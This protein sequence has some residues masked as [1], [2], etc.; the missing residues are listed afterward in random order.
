LRGQ[1]WNTNFIMLAM[2]NFPRINI[3]V[4]LWG[5]ML[6]N[7]KSQIDGIWTILPVL[8]TF[9][10]CVL[11][12]T[13]G[14]P[15]VVFAIPSF[16][17]L[18]AY[19][20][21]NEAPNGTPRDEK[22]P[23]YVELWDK[24]DSSQI[25]ASLPSPS[26]SVR[27][28]GSFSWMP[29]GSPLL[30]DIDLIVPAGSSLA[31]LGKVGSGKT[32][33]IMATLGELFPQG[34]ARI[35]IPRTIAF[36][37]QM[38][39]IMEGTLRGNVLSCGALDAERYNQ[40]I[41]ASCLSPDLEIL[42]GGDLV[43]IGSRGIALSGGQRARVSIARVA[44]SH[45]TVKVLDD[46]FSAL[47]ARTSRHVLDHY[48]FGDLLKNTT[49]IVVSQPDKDRIQRYDKVIILSEGRIACQGTPEEI[50][51]TEAYR[52][53]LNTE[54]AESLDQGKGATKAVEKLEVKQM[55][56]IRNSEEGFKLRDEE[57]QGRASWNDIWWF[58][59]CGGVFNLTVFLVVYWFSQLLHLVMMMVVQRWSS[60]EMSFKN[61]L[62]DATRNGWSYLPAYLFW[63]AATSATCFL[64]YNF[65]IQFTASKSENIHGEIVN[66]LLHAPMDRFFDKTPV[67][68]IMTRFSSDNMQMDTDFLD[69][70]F[71]V[72]NT[73]C[74][75]SVTLVWVHT[76]M[77]I[78][79]TLLTL[80]VYV[81]LCFILRRYFNTVIPLRYCLQRCQS[82][83]NDSLV[84]L[85]GGITYV[86]AEQ[87][88]SHKFVEFMQ[89]VDDQLAAGVGSETF[90]KRWLTVRL[91]MIVAFFTTNVVLITIW[92]PNAIDYGA[93]GLALLSLM[94]LILNLDNDIEAATKLQYQFIF[95]NRLQ[96]YTKVVQ[97]K[98]AVLDGDETY[99]SFATNLERQLL[100]EVSCISDS[101]SSLVSIA[102]K[103]PQ[104]QLDVVL[105]QKPDSNVFVAPIGKRLS[106]LD[107]TNSQLKQTGNWHQIASVNGVSKDASKM[108][109]EFCND[110]DV[111]IFVESGWIADG[112]KVSINGLYAGYADLPQMVL[113]NIDLEVE[114]RSNVAFVGATGCGKSTLL[115]CMLRILER[116]GGSISIND[117]DIADVGLSTLRNAV[118]LVPQDPVIMNASVRSNIDP[119][120]FYEDTQIWPALS[121][122]GLEEKVKSMP[123]LLDAP[124]GGDAA[125]LSFGQR[126]LF[127]LARL[128]VRQPRLILLDEATSALDP[129]SQ[130]IVQ[131]T[132]EKEFPNSTLMVIAHRLETILGFDKIV[133]L[134]QGRVVEQGSLEELKDVKGGLFAKMLAAKQ[135]Y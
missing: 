97:E 114:P 125:E 79:F 7:N 23:E 124:L 68:R 102:R 84:E 131:T 89:R 108:A 55:S 88:G 126:Q 15:Q 128:I 3:L 36:S 115:L 18:Q 96:E 37:N 134:H 118:G 62:V 104:G 81:S 10:A 90:V 8:G 107:P 58:I 2:F 50:M 67:G 41:F 39:Y 120:G 116:R 64:A 48:I 29:H 9:R 132:M 69:Q 133:V 117:I 72:V 30:K 74:Y 16:M 100:G 101:Q 21:L 99:W 26:C 52:E 83:T 31:I 130:E 106:D 22:V 5:F 85:D 112:A 63:M 113:K 80:P 66:R 110:K 56:Q 17:R 49:R 19:M 82:R 61:G 4:A 24:E 95:I 34:D 109:L 45:S 27:V 127:C 38:P 76:L 59:R 6:L 103:N 77:P 91:Y 13:M 14:L 129:K 33:L 60:D 119:F 42:P 65:A 122:V 12:A 71:Q 121:M 123:G 11:A 78:Y 40:A 111:K 86:R 98:P 47:D 44:F 70:F 135:T 20:K 53:L 25:Q 73:L 54:Q 87:V 46:P 35:S 57:A 51:Q 28:Q 32:S 105:V 92:I 93:L 1:F 94:A 43:P 75:D